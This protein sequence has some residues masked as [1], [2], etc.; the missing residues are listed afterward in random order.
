MIGGE[1]MI[2]VP[3]KLLFPRDN[4]T[5]TLTG[6]IKGGIPQPGLPPFSIPRHSVANHTLPVED[7]SFSD[8]ASNL[9]SAFIIIP[10]IAILESVAIAKAFCEFPTTKIVI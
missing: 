10:I 8:M 7:I 5:F 2:K 9:G 6:D 3:L 4:C 1:K